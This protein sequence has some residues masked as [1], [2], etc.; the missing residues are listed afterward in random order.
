M[1]THSQSLRV[2]LLLILIASSG[3]VNAKEDSF[4]KYVINSSGVMIELFAYYPDH[5]KP[6]DILIVFH[7]LKRKAKQLRN[8]AIKIAKQACLKV[9]APK[10][11]KHNFPNW[12]YHRAGV[13]RSGKVQPKKRWSDKVLNIVLQRIKE[14][15]GGNESRLFLFGHSAGGQFLSRITAYAPPANIHRVVIANPSVYVLPSLQENVPYGFSGIFSHD[16]A[17]KKLQ[18]YLALPITIYL[19]QRDV[20]EKYLVKSKQAIQQ[21]RNRLERGRYIFNRGKQI[22]Q[23]R[24]WRFNWQLVE[25][26][27]IGHSSKGML[28]AKELMLALGLADQ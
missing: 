2:L 27:G 13:Y 25:A 19:G 21:G 17:Y 24:G 22:A 6:R 11:D 26:P 9:F 7:G 8:K 16:Q 5:C 10:F 20:G 12:R 15:A 3:V 18:E 1:D 4:K 14:I 23:D 28:N